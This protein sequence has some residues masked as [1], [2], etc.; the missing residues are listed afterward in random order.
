M[1]PLCVRLHTMREALDSPDLFAD[2]LPGPSWAMW[3]VVLLASQGEALVTVEERAIFKDLTGRDHSSAEPCDDLICVVGR[4]G[5]KTRALAVLGAYLAG[6]IDYSAVQAPGERLKLAVLAATTKQ[7]TKAFNYILGVFEGSPELRT[8][9]VNKARPGEEPRYDVTMDTIRLCTDLDIEVVPANFKTVRGETLIGAL[10][11]EVAYWSVE[12]SANPDVEIL[13]AV[14]NGMGTTG[15]QLCVLSSPYARRGQLYETYKRHYGPQGDPSTLVV[16][17]ASLVMN[18]SLS[19]KVVE[20]AYERDA[21]KASA[22]YGAIFRKD[23]ETFISLDAIQACIEGTLTERGPVS[24]LRYFGFAD[25]SGGGADAMTLA[26]AH[27]EGDRTILDAVRE[28]YPGANP[29]AVVER[30]AATL[31]A[32]GLDKVTGDRYAG[33]WP[34][35]RFRA[36]GITYEV[37]E[38][39]KSEI[40]GA[41]LP[42]LNSGR[43]LLLPI[44]KL[45]QQLASLERRTS[46]GTGRD[47]I[48]HPQSKNAHDDVANAACGAIVGA[49]TKKISIMDLIY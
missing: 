13:D 40:Y 43:C 35:E 20:K 12:G 26:I 23:V 17:A 49:Q 36:H 1:N 22:E 41:F 14:R 9:L 30:F 45:E 44:P 29:D 4:R 11:D 19:P 21:A 39:S 34:R 48:D 31:K 15:G 46:R 8:L 27:K 37:S 5:G 25:P 2:L 7:A 24:S 3:R 38:K 10:A 47:I 42:I 6:C 28:E 16:Q 33:E 32:Y 18:P